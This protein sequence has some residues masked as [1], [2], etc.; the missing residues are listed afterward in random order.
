MSDTVAASIFQFVALRAPESVHRSAASLRFILDARVPSPASPDRVHDIAQDQ[1]VFARSPAAQLIFASAHANDPQVTSVKDVS[2]RNGMIAEEIEQAVPLDEKTGRPWVDHFAAIISGHLETFDKAR[3]AAELDAEVRRSRPGLAGLHDYVTL[4]REGGRSQFCIDYEHL[5]DRLYTLYVLKR[6][7]PLNLEYVIRGLQALHV[8]RLLDL[9]LARTAQRNK[10][11]LLVLWALLLRILQLLKLMK[12]GTAAD[13]LAV[14]TPVPAQDDRP[15]SNCAIVHLLAGGAESVPAFSLDSA[16]DLRWLFAATP[17]IHPFFGYLL[18]YYHPFNDV[19][20]IGI[21]DLLVVKQSLERYEPSEV[22]HIEN[23]LR[24]ESKKRSHRRLDRTEDVITV[25]RESNEESEKE[26]QSTARFELK[27]EAE[28]VSQENLSAEI[29]ASVSG[30]YGMIDFSVNTGMSYSTSKTESVRSAANFAKDTVDRSLTRVQKR[31][32]EERVSKRVYEVEELNEHGLDNTKGGGNLAGIYRYVD[33]RYRAQVYNYGKRL[34]FEFVVP[35]PAAFLKTAFAFNKENGDA[36]VRPTAPTLP[37]LVIDQIDDTIVND[38]AAR[39]NLTGIEPMPAE[40]TVASLPIQ[41]TNAGWSTRE[42]TL[43]VPPGYEAASARATGTRERGTNG[44]SGLYCSVGGENHLLGN[45]QRGQV[46]E[47]FDQPYANVGNPR[48][49]LGVSVLCYGMVSFSFNLDVVTHRTEEHL[50]DWQLKAYAK[51]MEAYERA[52]S[53][54]QSD[55]N[56]WQNKQAAYDEK[57]RSGIRGLNPGMNQEMM[58]TEL[59]KHCITMLARQFDSDPSDDDTFDAIRS[60][61]MHVT[62]NGKSVP[63]DIPA[64]DLDAARREGR[65]IQ[66]LEQAFE[67]PQL[68]YL[69]YPYFWAQMPDRWLEAQRYYEEIDPLF[70]KFLQAGSARVL[71]AVRP[72]YEVPVMHYLYTREPWNGGEAP[73]IDDVLYKPIYEELRDQQD[74]LNGATPYGDPWEVVVPTSLVYLQESA[75]LPTFDGKKS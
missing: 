68:T 54:Y 47:T 34:M 63:V 24:G 27:A 40:Q 28:T 45:D 15:R 58:R 11:C 55:L 42:F 60:L 23:V 65:I 67:W 51:I 73:G 74:D 38:W 66:F 62:R 69:L 49:K 21:G 1:A 22:A 75:E 46:V 7:H 19:K 43:D 17:S 56:D 29:S 4:A 25:D 48:T 13:S 41:M 6:R 18:A 2:I 59:K 14:G 16:A 44:A 26:L 71:I 70:A 61:P 31:V 36:P 37:A 50:R 35:D 39:Y 8:M 72:A 3:L 33:K 57:G 30:K 10:G 64:I 5:F 9:D 52:V 20:P 12:K 32:R 53:Q